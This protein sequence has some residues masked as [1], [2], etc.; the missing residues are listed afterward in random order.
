MIKQIHI[1]DLDGTVIDSSHR[2]SVIRKADGSIAIDFPFWVANRHR[3][4]D[5]EL[6]PLAEQYQAQLK[7]PEIYVIAA[8]ARVMSDVETQHVKTVL[9]WP[10]HMIS[11]AEGDNR[12][13]A[14]LKILGLNK[15]LNLAQFRNVTNRHFYED[16]LDYLKAVCEAHRCI[17]HFVPSKQGF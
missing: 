17:P 16:N 2:Y 9:G 6:L 3:A 14:L 1:Y 13:G 4:I 10:H 15:I 8:T 11:R 7:N 5:D 12:S